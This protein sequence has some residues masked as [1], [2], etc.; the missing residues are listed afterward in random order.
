ML[1]RFFWMLR[2][3]GVPATITEF[4]TLLEAL[5]TVPFFSSGKKGTVPPDNL[6]AVERFYFIVRAILVKDDRH[7]DRFD[8]AFAAHFRGAEAAFDALLAAKVP[9]GS[10][11][12]SRA[13][14][15]A[16]RK[17]ERTT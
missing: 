13:Q 17:A 12:A 5:A 2:A 8:R 15:S 10:S 3:A 14:A 7:Y 4:L 6:T 1:I 11:S 9:A 16:T